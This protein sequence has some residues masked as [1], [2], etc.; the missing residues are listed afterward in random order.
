MGSYRTKSDE[1][2]ALALE[3]ARLLHEEVNPEDMEAC[4]NYANANPHSEMCATH[5]YCDSNQVM[6]DAFKAVMGREM[7]IFCPEDTKLSCFAWDLARR[8]GY[9][10]DPYVSNR[11]FK[12]WS[13]AGILVS[14]LGSPALV[15]GQHAAE[16]GLNGLEGIAYGDGSFMVKDGFAAYTVLLGNESYNGSHQS[17]ELI[18]WALHARNNQ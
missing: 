16:C 7:G 8:L 17:M 2:V 4:V 9:S 11:A 5:D 12:D 14:D 3:F 18:L 1:A 10:P 13:V 15:C 6:L